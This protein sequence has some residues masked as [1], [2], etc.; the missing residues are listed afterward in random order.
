LFEAPNI[1]GIALVK[2]VN[3][4]LAKFEL[5]NKVITCVKYESKNL[6]TLKFSLSDDVSFGVL[7]LERPYSRCVLDM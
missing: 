7:Q 4:F 5:I 3:F 2:I 1:G 6:A